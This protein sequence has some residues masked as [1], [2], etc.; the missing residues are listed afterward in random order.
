[1]NI[2][3]E[4]LEDIRRAGNLRHIPDPSPVVFDLSS[5]DYMGLRCIMP[6]L[7]HEF[8]ESYPDVSFSSSASRLL[9]QDQEIY[10]MLEN[11]L[12]SIYGRPALLFNSGYHANT[13]IIPALAVPGTLIVA[14][15]LVHASIIDGIR[16]S[17]CD[18]KRFPHNDVQAARD[19]LR[20]HAAE[21]RNLLLVTEGVFSMDGDIAPLREFVELKKEFPGLMLYVDEAHGFG[22]RGELGLGACE[23]AGV[24]DYIDII[25]GTL[26]KAACSEG[27]FAISS[28]KK[29][30]VNTCRSFIFSTAIAPANA[31]WSLTTIPRLIDMRRERNR[32]KEISRRFRASLNE[33]GFDVPCGDSPIVPVAAGDPERAVAM[34]ARLR[35]DGVLALPI[36]YPTVPRG[37]DRL[38]VSLNAALSDLDI[39][40]ILKSFALLLRN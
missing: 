3:S 29:Y 17:R 16:L 28:L 22:T 33:M 26:G 18:F 4:I 20:K 14:D 13:G 5:N 40:M 11:M 25:V 12:A 24:C 32:L 8:D 1:M 38:R 37:T 35:E 30:L 21:Y 27:A 23:E 6:L 15:R 7:R 31:A 2:Y 19:M 34:S 36:R 10:K 9:A 39:D